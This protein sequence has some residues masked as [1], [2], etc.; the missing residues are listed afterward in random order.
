[1]HELERSY[2]I[3]LNMLSKGNRSFASKT[4]TLLI[5]E[6]ESMRL[7]R[8][9]E[10]LVE[11]MEHEKRE[12]VY[13]DQQI[14]LLQEE[15]KQL[16]ATKKTIYPSS[17]SEE[18]QRNKC[19]VLE[20]KIGLE[21]THLNETK[22]QSQALRNEV[23]GYRKDKSHYKRTLQNLKED[24]FSFSKATDEKKQEYQHGIELE[25]RYKKQIQNLRSKSMLE[26]SQYSEKISDYS[27]FIK[28]KIETR[29]QIHKQ[30]EDGILGQIKRHTDTVEI[31]K[32]QKKLLER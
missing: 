5:R 15:L 30:I 8:D 16:K 10:K 25:N 31:S 24:I 13:L 1:M 22:A 7:G 12:S 20:K 26:R 32:L 2:L 27:V 21:V 11:Y 14:A 19:I 4:G 3:I 9:T 29:K 23:N 17:A 18:Q 28:E 6:P